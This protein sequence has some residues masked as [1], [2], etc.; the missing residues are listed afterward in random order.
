L[1]PL[2][3][4]EVRG[5]FAGGG[6]IFRIAPANQRLPFKLHT[7]RAISKPLATSKREDNTGEWLGIAVM[8]HAIECIRC[9][10]LVRIPVF[11]DCCCLSCYYRLLKQATHNTKLCK[12]TPLQK[13]FLQDFYRGSVPESAIFSFFWLYHL[14]PVSLDVGVWWRQ[15]LISRMVASC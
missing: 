8:C 2:R 1:G 10:Q 7:T 15:S 14:A 12:G 5:H 11:V 3:E 4:E 6:K 9:S 13:D